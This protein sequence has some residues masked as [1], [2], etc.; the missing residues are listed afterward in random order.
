[1]ALINAKK[2]AD[3]EKIKLD[4]DKEIYAKIQKYSTWSGITKIEHFLKKRLLLFFR[5][6]KSGKITFVQSNVKK[7]KSRCEYFV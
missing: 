6:T 5:K 1:M 3:E 2:I 4:I 7:L